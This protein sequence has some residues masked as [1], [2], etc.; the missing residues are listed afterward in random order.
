M[1][2]TKTRSIGLNIGQCGVICGGW[3]AQI[4]RSSLFLW[5]DSPIMIES[6]RFGKLWGVDYYVLAKKLNVN[7]WASIEPTFKGYRL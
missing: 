1:K 3:A 5:V 7:S 2:T 6:M 4:T